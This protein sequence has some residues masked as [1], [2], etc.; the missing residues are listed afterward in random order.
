LS[1]RAALEKRIGHQFSE[2]R[3]LEQAL[4]HRGFSA[5]NNERL[6]FLGDAVL[7]C[8]MC[9]TL[10]AQFPEASEGQ[11]TRLLESLVRAETL[12]NLAAKLDLDKELKLA[13]QPLGGGLEDGPSQSMRADAL[14]AVFGAV[15]VDGG[16]DA[17]KKAIL[18]IYGRIMET[19]DPR[20]VRKDPKSALNELLLKRYQ[21]VPEYRLLSESRATRKEVF[22][23]ECRV[24]ILDLATRGTGPSRQQAQQEAA[25]AMLEKLEK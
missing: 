10:Y 3:L 11:L 23:M 25:R 15:F 22:E 1:R 8:V 17:A 18:H 24:P 7:D 19:L 2:P 12:S 16:Y 20:H 13:G 9:E 21:S 4:T 5:D 6:E 14:E